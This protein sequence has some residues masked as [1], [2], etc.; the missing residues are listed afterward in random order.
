MRHECVVDGFDDNYI[1]VR[2]SWTRRQIRDFWRL[3]IAPEDY[4]T[5]CMLAISKVEACHLS[6]EDGRVIDKPTELTADVLDGDIDYRVY[7]WFVVAMIDAVNK[8]QSLGEVTR[9][10]LFGTSA[11]E[12]TAAAEESPTH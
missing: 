1:E 6:T 7:D 9:R 4:K 12:T 8:V 3:I 11:D 2:E 5:W 10:R